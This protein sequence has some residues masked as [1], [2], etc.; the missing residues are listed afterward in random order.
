MCEELSQIQFSVPVTHIY[1]PLEYAAETHRCY[2][3]RYGNSRKRV[4]FM[5]MNPGPFGMAQNG[6]P[7]GDAKFARDWLKI[8]GRVGKPPREHPKRI[9]YG[10]D[11]PRSEV[12]G[13]R[14]WGLM[15]SLCGTPEVFF[16]NCFV[17]NYCP[18][19]FM[20]PSG[21]NVTPPEMKIHERGR[22]QEICDRSLLETVKLLE[23]EQVVA[24]GR[25]PEMRVRA[26][27]KESSGREVR[28][29]RI[30]H[31]S[32]IN[33]AANRG[34]SEAATAQL[35]ELGLLEVVRGTV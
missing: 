29:V 22:M 16:R 13:T 28:V 18:L 21:K 24:V 35:S 1:N 12:S 25:Y 32:P 26:A 9:I 14:F 4:L 2:I 31:P 3:S 7:F 11:C 27:L 19:C 15:E 33:P 5:G 34:W 20:A 10:L 6:V 23:V 8:S 30:T 17:H